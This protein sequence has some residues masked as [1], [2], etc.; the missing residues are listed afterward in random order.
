[1]TKLLAALIASSMFAAGAFAANAAA[2]A[3]SAPAKKAT[4]HTTAKKAKDAA[5]AASK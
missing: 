5:S 4:H 2:P 3:A 1:M